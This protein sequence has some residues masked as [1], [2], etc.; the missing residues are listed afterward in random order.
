[1]DELHRAL[2]EHGISTVK[3]VALAVLEVDGSISCLKYDDIKPDAS[4]H[5]VRRKFLQKKQ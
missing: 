1:M 4:T 3:D 5:L 2:R